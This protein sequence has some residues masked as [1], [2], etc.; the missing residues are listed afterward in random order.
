ME[1]VLLSKLI[2][3]VFPDRKV[4]YTVK[5]LLGIFNI[6]LQQEAF[7]FLWFIVAIK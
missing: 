5:E 1:S 2:G 4:H 7:F 6:F 3:I